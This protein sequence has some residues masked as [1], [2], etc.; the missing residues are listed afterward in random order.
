[1]KKT[2]LGGLVGGFI[3]FVWGVIAWMVLPLHE[4][5]LRRI[6]NED[7]VIAALRSSMDTKG[8]YLFPS[9]PK[10]AYDKPV[11]EQEAAMKAWEEKRRRGPIGLIIYHPQGG[12]PFMA[13]HFVIGLIVNIISALFV[14]WFL[15]RS[16]AFASSYMARVAF[17]GMLGIFASFAVHLPYWNWMYFPFDYTTAMIADTVFGWVLAGLGIAAIVKP[18]KLE[19]A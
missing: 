18:P 7:S 13:R 10:M 19:A 5:S 2:L 6:S 4:A 1:M 14:A 11:A 17:C 15:S 8:V 9:T 16:T 12:E 3:L